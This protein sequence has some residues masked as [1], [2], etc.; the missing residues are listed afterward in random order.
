MALD[1]NFT[2]KGENASK[3]VAENARMINNN[4]LF[5]TGNPS[6]NSYDFLK[7]F[8]TFYDLLIDLLNEK[9]N[10]FQEVKE[11]K[12]KISKIDE[13][14]DFVL[15][16][17]QSITKDTKKKKTEY[18]G[19]KKCLKNAI[20]LYDNRNEF[21]NAFVNK[22][23]SSGNVEGDIF[24]IPK[25][26][27]LEPL[28]EESTS[29]RAKMGR[30]EKSDEENQEGQGLKILTPNKMLSRLPIILAQLKA[31]NNPEKLKNEIRQ[32]CI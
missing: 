2:K 3:K 22:H 1:M 20:K 31:G 28:I 30:Q 19:T 26:L 32:L 15:L 5:K 16:E 27:K 13:L 24:D 21:I 6:I 11:Q 29:G 14:K 18:Y 9:I 12:E 4:L 17:E 8:G 10:I 7:R 25:D 23:I